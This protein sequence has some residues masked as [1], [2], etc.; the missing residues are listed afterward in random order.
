MARHKAKLLRL[1]T[2]VAATKDYEKQLD[3]HFG[4]S[5]E[6]C[7]SENIT[8]SFVRIA[9]GHRSRAHYHI[10]GE[11]AQYFIKGKGRYIVGYGTEDEEVHEFGP[12]CFIYIPRGVIHVIE[13]TGTED[14]ESIAAYPCPS[15]EAT[16]KFFCEM[17]LEGL[18][19]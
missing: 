10:N 7:G 14:I 18:K 6:S 19:D 12:G 2:E 16:G 13:N 8:M 17:P 5:K 11:L 15:G 3:H 1:Q 4:I 9:P